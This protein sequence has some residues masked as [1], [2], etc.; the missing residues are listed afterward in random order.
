MQGWQTQDLRSF[1]FYK[2]L[3]T[4]GNGRRYPGQGLRGTGAAQV[5][6]DGLENLQLAKGDVHGRMYA[7]NSNK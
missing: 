5:A 2:I 3:E 7:I 4:Q 1:L 6:G